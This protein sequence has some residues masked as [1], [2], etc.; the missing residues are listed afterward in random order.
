MARVLSKSKILSFLQCP[1]RLWLEVH[2]PDLIE[3]SASAQQRFAAGH[4]VGEVARKLYDPDG[5]GALIDVQTEGFSGALARSQELLGKNQPIFE[6]GFAAEGALAFA[7]IMLPAR[8]AGK[9]V[10]HMVEV[11][12]STSLKDYHRKDAAIQTF[13]A[14]KAGVPLASVALAHVD[15]Q[16]VYPGEGNYSG[17]LIENDLTDEAMGME[18]EVREWIQEAQSVV[19]KRNEPDIEVGTQCKTPFECPFIGH[20]VEEIPMAKH[21]VEWLP[22][23]QKKEILKLIANGATDMREIP[24]SLLNER[25]LR[26]KQATLTGKPYFDAKGASKA[27]SQHPLPAYFVDFETIGF[28]VPRWKGTRP[29][30]HVP[31]QF[32]LHYMAKPGKLEHHEFLDLSG[33]DPSRD[34]AERLIKVCGTSGPIFVYNKSFENRII[35]ELADRMKD[36]KPALEKISKRLVDLLPLTKAH[37]YHPSQKGSWSIKAVLPAIMGVGYDSLDGVSDGGMAMEA[38]LEAVSPDTSHERKQRIEKD[39]LQYCHLD[40]K[41]MVEIWSYFN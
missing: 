23:L 19:R 4:E 28:A 8:K 35:T 22:G 9:K 24:D 33:K 25:Q 36:L 21:P 18:P 26:V 20:C 6:A 27:L 17:L 34:F 38:Y 10:W 39:L 1:K 15:T 13:I 37:Y 40:T 12:S 32:S 14:R 5:K 7:D 2:Q 29:Y 41:A 3:E 16:W 30:Q 31:F 11:K